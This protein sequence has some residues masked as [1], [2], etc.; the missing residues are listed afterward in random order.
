MTYIIGRADSHGAFLAGDRLSTR[1]YGGGNVEQYD[2]HCN[3]MVVYA[4]RDGIVAIGFSGDAFVGSVPTD[5]WIASTLWNIRPVPGE[6]I[7]PTSACLHDSRP[8]AT[9]AESMFQLK[10]CIN[11][12]RSINRLDILVTGWWSRSKKWTP[13]LH[14]WT[15]GWSFGKNPKGPF[16]QIPKPDQLGC[17]GDLPTETDLLEDFLKVQQTVNGN[18]NRAVAHKMASLVR[19]SARRSPKIGSDVVTITIQ[20]ASVWEAHIEFFPSQD[21]IRPVAFGDVSTWNPVAVSPWL[22]TSALT[23][24]PMVMTPNVSIQ[25]NPA[26]YFHRA[27][28]HPPVTAGGLSVQGR[29][30]WPPARK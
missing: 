10:K 18:D 16:G 14:Q 24:P 8:M 25:G 19:H 11:A 22:L 3:K 27:G 17:I 7:M 15:K 12:Q 21:A 6:A 28:G 13:L 20:P 23:Q 26:F 9:L 2:Q 30:V 29:A 5:T 4:A 1:D